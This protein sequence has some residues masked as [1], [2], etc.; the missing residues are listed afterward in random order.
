M[1]RDKVYQHV[2]QGTDAWGEDHEYV[3]H[4][5]FRPLRIAGRYIHRGGSKPHGV[6]WQFTCDRL[7]QDGR[8]TQYEDRP[9]MCHFFE[10]KSDLL[11][12]EYEGSYKGYLTLYPEENEHED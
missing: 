10:P 4:P 8:C 12:I 5:Y 11:C 6:K 9:K 3:P 1:S 2:A 7:G